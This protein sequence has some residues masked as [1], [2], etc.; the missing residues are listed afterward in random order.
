MGFHI[1][2][3]LGEAIR[4][5]E[6]RIEYLKVHKLA[7]KENKIKEIQ[8]HISSATLLLNQLQEE[9]EY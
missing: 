4:F 5:V 6:K 7:T 9:M 1:E 3:T 2:F 8:E